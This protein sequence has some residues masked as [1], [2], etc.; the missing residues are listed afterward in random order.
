MISIQESYIWTFWKS[1]LVHNVF[2]NSNIVAI[3]TGF[4]SHT[5][6][7][8]G[9]LNSKY[10]FIERLVF[11]NLISLLKNGNIENILN[12]FTV[13]EKNNFVVFCKKLKVS[14]MSLWI[15]ISCK[16]LK[17]LIAFSMGERNTP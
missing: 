9:K 12:S 5:N 7:N 17:D 2:I 13:A 6:K 11:K 8:L 15:T 4:A 3:K 10:E 1:C 14:N 16:F